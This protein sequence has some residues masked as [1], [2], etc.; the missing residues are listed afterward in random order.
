[1]ILEREDKKSGNGIRYPNVNR[2]PGQ[3]GQTPHDPLLRGVQKAPGAIADQLGDQKDQ[4][5]RKR[6]KYPNGLR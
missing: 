2:L 1:M 4:V 6:L 5:G 3:A